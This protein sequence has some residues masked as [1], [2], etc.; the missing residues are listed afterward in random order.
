MIFGCRLFGLSLSLLDSR[1]GFGSEKRCIAREIL[2]HIG[3]LV[4]YHS[5]RRRFSWGLGNGDANWRNEFERLKQSHFAW[6]GIKCD[7]HG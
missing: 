1:V 7:T 2:F 4:E 6:K 3:G 5:H